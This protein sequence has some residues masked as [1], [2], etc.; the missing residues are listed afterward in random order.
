MSE[1]RGMN[2]NWALR[3]KVSAGIVAISPPWPSGPLPAPTRTCPLPPRPRCCGT[4]GGG[5][6]WHRS[7]A[8]VRCRHWGLRSRAAPLQGRRPAHRGFGQPYRRHSTP[9][10]VLLRKL[11]DKKDIRW[12]VLSAA[13]AE[14][15]GV[16]ARDREAPARQGRTAQVARKFPGVPVY[17]CEDRLQGLEQMHKVVWPMPS[18]STMACSTANSAPPSALPGGHDPTRR[19]GP[20]PA[21]GR[22]RDLPERIQEADAVI[23][24]RCPAAL[25]K[26]DL[27]LWRHRLHLTADQPLLHGHRCNSLRAMASKRYA[28]WPMRC[29]AVSGMPSRPN[30]KPNSAAIAGSFTI[31]PTPTTNPSPRTMSR[32]GGPPWSVQMTEPTSGGSH[33]GERRR[34][35]PAAGR[36]RRPSHHGPPP[37]HSLVTRPR[38]PVGTVRQRVEAS[39]SNPIFIMRLLFPFS[40]LI[41]L[42][43]AWT[44]CSSPASHA[45]GG[46]LEEPATPP[47]PC[48]VSARRATSPLTRSKRMLRSLRLPPAFS[49]GAGISACGTEPVL[50]H[51]RFPVAHLRLRQ[52][53]SKRASPPTSS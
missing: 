2:Q 13:M 40:F 8:G 27:R 6:R 23:L 10:S 44:G 19:P 42:G 15:P 1:M 43:L 21:R 48:R 20:F 29:I 31:S 49:N 5:H 12:A 33:H 16:P 28:G 41:A 4:G 45:L 9:T 37:S 24:T 46:Q 34:T 53:P 14:R 3:R 22:L 30:S 26:G 11:M 52:L 32:N 17:V 35:H 51:R 25:T 50:H 47:S 38:W 18:S 36:S 39:R 7:T